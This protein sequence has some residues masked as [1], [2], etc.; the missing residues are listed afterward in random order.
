[1]NCIGKPRSDRVLDE[2]VRLKLTRIQVEGDGAIS[3][4]TGK[5]RREVHV[6]RIIKSVTSA[7]SQVVFKEGREGWS[8]RQLQKCV[9]G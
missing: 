8:G 4:L 6:S 2:E 1:M 7:G 9:E 5:G 3:K